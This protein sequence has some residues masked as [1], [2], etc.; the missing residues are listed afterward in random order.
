MLTKLLVLVVCVYMSAAHLC[1]LS[2]PQRT[3]LDNINKPGSASCI[4]LVEPCGKTKPSMNKVYMEA[5]GN[6]T[7]VFQK[8][9][10]HYNAE[11]PG[12][13]SVSMG[14]ENGVLKELYNTPDTATPSLTIF[15]ANITV[16][17]V[18]TRVSKMILQ[19]KYVTKNPKAP[20]VFYQCA[21]VVV[22]KPGEW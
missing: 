16:P 9:L 10:D 20:P 5:G 8:N 22:I 17:D 21:D 14:K 12:Y 7:V 18:S 2:P 11:S 19:T 6:F 3:A 4:L 1:M 13:W 15:S